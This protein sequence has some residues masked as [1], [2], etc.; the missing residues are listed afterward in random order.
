[1]QSRATPCAYFRVQ[2]ALVCLTKKWWLPL[3]K[4]HRYT[5]LGLGVSIVTTTS[6]LF[7]FLLH[8]TI[9]TYSYFTIWERISQ[10]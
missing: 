10:R 3:F 8:G 1:M 5:G 9:R 7:E 4:I 2:F 6:P